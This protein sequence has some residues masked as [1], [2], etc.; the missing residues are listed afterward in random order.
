VKLDGGTFGVLQ[1]WVVM[2]ARKPGLAFDHLE[3]M[4][5]AIALKGLEIY[6]PVTTMLNMSMIKPASIQ[7]SSKEIPRSQ[8]RGE[9]KTSSQSCARV[10]ISSATFPLK[11]RLQGKPSVCHWR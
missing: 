1:G 6:Q 5:V 8:A 10:E 2:Q 3:E 7:A 9:Q 4:L 11:S